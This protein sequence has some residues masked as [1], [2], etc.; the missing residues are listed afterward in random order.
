MTGT[1]FN[2]RPFHANNPRILG[3]RHVRSSAVLIF[4][5]ANPQQMEARENGDQQFPNIRIQ[6]FGALEKKTHS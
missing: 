3:S 1:E 2:A 4:V 5:A 6:D